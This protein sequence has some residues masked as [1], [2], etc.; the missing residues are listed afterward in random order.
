MNRNNFKVDNINPGADE[1]VTIYVLLDAWGKSS[2]DVAHC[3]LVR[4]AT[5]E[6]V[7]NLKDAKPDGGYFLNC[8]HAQGNV[9]LFSF[10][11]KQ[12][13][14]ADDYHRAVT[15]VADAFASAYEDKASALN[16]STRISPP[17]YPSVGAYVMSKENAARDFKRSRDYAY[18]DAVKAHAR[19]LWDERT[20]RHSSVTALL[21]NLHNA[22]EDIAPELLYGTTIQGSTQ[23]LFVGKL[24]DLDIVHMM[25]DPTNP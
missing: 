19:L 23:A 14:G 25:S 8:A 21:G 20:V 22:G 16:G 12:G 7:H 18:R 24:S 11:A 4:N 2:A 5:L 15:L 17:P 13:W 9:V 3:N 6:V 10:S 1:I